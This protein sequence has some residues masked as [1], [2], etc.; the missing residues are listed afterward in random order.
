MK[1]VEIE[2]CPCSK[3]KPPRHGSYL[4]TIVDYENYVGIRKYSIWNR[5]CKYSIWN[6]WKNHDIIAW[7]E[8]PEPFDSRKKSSLKEDW[9]SY[10]DEKPSIYGAYLSTVA[11][12]KKRSVSI[13][14]WLPSTDRFFNEGDH[15]IIA[16]AE[17]PE[18]Y[19]EEDYE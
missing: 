17:L 9:H 2:W 7:A 16:W 5:W 10:P 11:I 6:R 1:K 14:L 8:L 3:K 19:R 12:K 18:P 4:V 15:S 13:S